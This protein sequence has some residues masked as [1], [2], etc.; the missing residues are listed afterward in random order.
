MELKIEYFQDV[1]YDRIAALEKTFR[2]SE[3]PVLI[4]KG[5]GGKTY[6]YHIKI[7]NNIDLI[8]D[9][10]AKIVPCVSVDIPENANAEDILVMS[11]QL[12]DMAIRYDNA[13]RQE[14]QNWQSASTCEY[15]LPLDSGYTLLKWKK[16]NKLGIDYVLIMPYALCLSKKLYKYREKDFTKS[17]DEDIIINIGLDL[18]KALENLE[19]LKNPICHRD[20]KPDN[21]YW[22]DKKSCYCLGDFG[23]AAIEDRTQY[24]N[25]GTMDYWSP[26]QAFHW[27]QS[28]RDHRQ[29]IYS[30]GLVLY[31]LADTV[32][33]RVH[34]HERLYEKRLPELLE[35]KVSPELNKVIHKACE[36]EVNNRYQHACE[37]KHALQLIK[38]PDIRNEFQKKD[39]TK[40]PQNTQT[41]YARNTVNSEADS[42]SKDLE[43]IFLDKLVDKFLEVIDKLNSKKSTSDFFIDPK[44]I[45][46]VIVSII[47]FI[48]V[49]LL[50]IFDKTISLPMIVNEIFRPGKITKRY[51]L[52]I[53]IPVFQSIQI[54]NVLK[55]ITIYKHLINKILIW[56]G[57]FNFWAGF[58]LIA[59]GCRDINALSLVLVF[60]II[61]MF[62]ETFTITEKPLSID[63]LKNKELFQKWSDNELKLLMICYEY[64]TG[65]LVRL[66]LSYI[67]GALGQLICMI[68]VERILTLFGKVELL[69]ISIIIAMPLLLQINAYIVNF[70]ICH[71]IKTYSRDKVEKI[72]LH[73]CI[74]GISFFFLPIIIIIIVLV[75]GPISQMLKDSLN[76]IFS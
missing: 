6:V 12:S 25:T 9:K 31:E 76:N 41:P 10:A 45:I 13:M 68:V 26:E 37:F 11:E 44:N 48:G 62:Y 1:E 46:Y 43:Q 17:V 36:F 38:N 20:I 72:D 51:L 22:W 16:D 65:E 61:L 30:L 21:I 56:I 70:C 24:T 2:L 28:E 63:V 7:I 8:E 57:C 59:V 23:I 54:M 58:S 15:I 32:P 73:G 14:I 49:Y 42:T 3:K 74:L 47:L 18:C 19:N 52:M 64:I 39:Q 53:A 34:Y 4:G 50:V 71:F 29:D 55:K 75:T 35:E 69:Q 66:F 67:I 33:I 60:F 27:P 5:S 40:F